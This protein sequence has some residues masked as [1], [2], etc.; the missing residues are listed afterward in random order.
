[1]AEETAETELDTARKEVERLRGL[2]R[3]DPK[4]VLIAYEDGVHMRLSRA[5]ADATERAD[6]AE[7]ALTEA[8]AR[9][10][11]LEGF[12]DAVRKLA[13]TFKGAHKLAGPHDPR[14]RPA[15][16]GMGCRGLRRWQGF[17][18]LGPHPSPR[19]HRRRTPMTDL[20]ELE[21]LAKAA[22]PGPWNDRGT[23]IDDF[24]RE[25]EASLSFEWTPNGIG[26]P[27]LND[28]FLNDAAFIAA[29]N[30]T[31]LLALIARVRAAEGDKRRM[32][33]LVSQDV[34]V[35][36]PLVYGSRKLFA[37]QAVG[38]LDADDAYRTTLRDQI[39]AALEA[40]NV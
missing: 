19:H 34:D 2:L 36:T 17:T 23:S 24:G 10:A 5:A 4:T 15:E 7:S 31:T 13:I 3:D 21:A 25:Y 14:S 35:R 9:I 28:N 39:D 8:K 33:W 32:D 30:P 12:V 11:E 18:G 37:A 6:T 20:D 26:D 38:D 22:T 16:Q 27:G 40:G 29:A 1:M